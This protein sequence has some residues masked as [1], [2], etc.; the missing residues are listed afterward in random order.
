MKQQLW[1]V[2][3]SEIA[4]PGATI[5]IGEAKVGKLTSIAETTEGYI[6]LAYIRTKAGGQGLK[7]KVGDVTGDIIAIPFAARGYLDQKGEM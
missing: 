3:L 7:V 1:G 4:L 2:K 6:G 5:T